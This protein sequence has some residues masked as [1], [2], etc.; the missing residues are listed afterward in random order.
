MKCIS[1]EMQ[2][3]PKWKHAIDINTCPFCGRFIMDEELKE[4]FSSLCDT[5]EDLTSYQDQLDDWMLSNHNYIKT[6][7]DKLIS[8]VPQEY[9][10]SLKQEAVDKYKQDLDLD[11]EDFEKRKNKKFKVKVTTEAGEQEVVAEK[12]Q[13]EEKTNGFY[14]RAEAVK[15]NI[16]G[17]KSVAEK[18]QHLKAMA[19]QIKREGATVVN[20]AG[21]AGLITPDMMES[22]DPET[23]AEMQSLMSSGDIINSA[24]P[25]SEFTGEDEIPAAVLKM[26]NMAQGGGKG[27]QADL[28]KLQQLQNRVSGSRKNF[29]SGGGGFS[30]A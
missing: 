18:T 23:V 16:E 1:C 29:L 28:A 4:L 26:A 30:R 25:D 13:S 7:S 12:I 9:L 3:D 10:D 8:Y 5:M 15:P 17:F 14:N 2:I 24:L 27:S 21:M 11:T 6:T 20:Q 19:Q 22:A